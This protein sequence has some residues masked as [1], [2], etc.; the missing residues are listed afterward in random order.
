LYL[1]SYPEDYEIWTRELIWRWMGEGFILKEQGR[2]LYE[3]GEDYINELINRSLIQPSRLNHD[4]NK[5]VVC[6]VHDMVLD[7]IT[8]LAN[9]DGFLATI[10]DQQPKCQQDRIHRLSLQTSNEEDINHLSAANLCHVRSLIIADVFP[11]AFKWLPPLST[12]PVLRVVCLTGCEEVDNRCFKEICKLIHLRYLG[13]GYTSITEIPKEIQNL[14]LL[15]VL[16]VRG[17][18]IHELPSTFVLPRKLKCLRADTLYR[19]W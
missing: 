19:V 1:S 3:V 15:Q 14:Q 2:S 10:H 7:L 6:R 13:L 12:F 8:R 5:V 17:T 18:G 9:E 16:D 11:E 4:S